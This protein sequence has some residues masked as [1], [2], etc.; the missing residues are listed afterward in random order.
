MVL[1]HILD[2]DKQDKNNNTYWGVVG[3]CAVTN[4]LRTTEK[5]GNFRLESDNVEINRLECLSTNIHS[6]TAE[7]RSKIISMKLSRLSVL[8]II[9]L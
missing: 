4:N 1:L 6:R 9:V 8:I 2:L 3:N 7:L 5:I